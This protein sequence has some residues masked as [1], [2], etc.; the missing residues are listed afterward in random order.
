MAVKLK[1]VWGHIQRPWGYEVRV[2]FTDGEHIYNRCITT[3]KELSTAD[4]DL[5]IA[6]LQ[7][8][9]ERDVAL[10]IAETAKP[11]ELAKEEL[12]EK[13]VSLEIEKSELL[14]EIES[15]SRL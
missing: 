7:N 4:L 5:K 1:S 12:L 13:I 14:A 6:V 9:V 8:A 15:L 10:E 2:D 3:E 11:V